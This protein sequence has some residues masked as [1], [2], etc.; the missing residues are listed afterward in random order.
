ERRG[1]PVGDD[2]PVDRTIAVNEVAR[3]QSG[4]PPPD[5]WHVTVERR[6]QI[7]ALADLLEG[8]PGPIPVVLHAGAATR[9]MGAGIAQGWAVRTAL[10]AI[11]SQS[12]VRQGTG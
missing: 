6:E 4:P 9:R 8:S 10:E 12:G 2:A 5:A 1:A 7:E 3:Y 11:F